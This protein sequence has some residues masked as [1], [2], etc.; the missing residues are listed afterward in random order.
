MIAAAFSLTRHI[1]TPL[2]EVTDIAEKIAAG[3]LLVNLS[4]NGRTDEIGKLTQVFG[5]MTAYLKQTAKMAES[6]AGGD[7]RITVKPQSEKDL[8]GNALATIVEFL[9]RNTAEFAEGANVLASSAK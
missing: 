1:S 8:L 7:L 6:I 4:M 2:K 5:R 3:D 9:R